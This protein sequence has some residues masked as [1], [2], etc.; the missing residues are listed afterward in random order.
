MWL[1][2]AIEKAR[3]AG[4]SHHLLSTSPGSACERKVLNTLKRLWWCC[5]IRD[6]IM[7]LGLRRSMHISSL[8]SDINKYP[9][10]EFEDLADEIPFSRVYTPDLKRELIGILIQLVKFCVILTE[11]LESLFPF[12]HSNESGILDDAKVRPNA[13]ALD[14]WF[15][16]LIQRKFKASNHD[17]IVLYHNHFVGITKFAAYRPPS[18]F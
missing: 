6:R 3:D 13:T 12:V 16:K 14:K 11:V 18:N 7:S 17:S 1:V 9:R 15:D 2:I 4:A 5:T 8:I 10:L